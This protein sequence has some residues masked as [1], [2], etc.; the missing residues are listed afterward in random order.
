MGFKRDL[1]EIEN[2]IK[3]QRYA[4]LIG[5]LRGITLFY[6]GEVTAALFNNLYSP[7]KVFFLT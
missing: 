3:A 6:A 7:Q 1:T 5:V 4:V 2:C